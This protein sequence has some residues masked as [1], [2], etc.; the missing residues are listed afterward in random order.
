MTVGSLVF[1][2]TDALRTRQALTVGVLLAGLGLLC[3]A[4]ALRRGLARDWRGALLVGISG[5]AMLAWLWFVR[6]GFVGASRASGRA[7]HDS[8]P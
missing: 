1:G 7:R 3:A 2:F 4:I 5:A 8:S 6:F